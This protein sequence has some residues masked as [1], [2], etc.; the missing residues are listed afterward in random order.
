VFLERAAALADRVVHDQPGHIGHLS[1]MRSL[2]VSKAAPEADDIAD[3]PSQILKR[4]CP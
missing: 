1:R 4:T 3:E 2:Q